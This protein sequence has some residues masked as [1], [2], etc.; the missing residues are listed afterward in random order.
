ML[1]GGGVF[2][3]SRCKECGPALGTR[4]RHSHGTRMPQAVAGSRRRTVSLRAA[5][6]QARQ[7]CRKVPPYQETSLRVFEKGTGN[8]L[9]ATFQNTTVAAT[10]RRIE[11]GHDFAVSASSPRHDAGTRVD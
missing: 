2:G 9:V 3:R 1:P 8:W 7:Q 4:H 11:T 5:L 10:R 6:R